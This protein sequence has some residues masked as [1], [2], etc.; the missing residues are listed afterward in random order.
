MSN[1]NSIAYVMVPH[2]SGIATGT[3]QQMAPLAAVNVNGGEQGLLL[4]STMVAS[5]DG[6]NPVSIVG[7]TDSA[8]SVAPLSGGFTNLYQGSV[9]RLTGYDEVNNVW[10]RLRAGI[11]DFGPA[12]L[13]VLADKLIAVSRLQAIGINAEQWRS[14]LA[15]ASDTDGLGGA[16]ND[17][18]LMVTPFPHGFNGATWDRLRTLNAT[19]DSPDS[20]LSGAQIAGSP[21]EWSVNNEPAVAARATVTKANNGAGTR[22][23]CKSITA[24]LA[25]DGT[26]S[27]ANVFV[28]LRDGGGA[29]TILWSAT[30]RGPVNSTN[31]I[32]IS[33]LNIVGSD[34]TDMTLEFSAAPNAN[35]QQVV[36]MT[37]IT[38]AS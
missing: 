11:D 8:D 3:P 21:L 2:G 26:A 6:G 20:A 18:S 14:L 13:G 33:G 27:N 9:A 15:C 16:T 37:G 23:V 38:V 22:L 24:T 1:L 31:V 25:C 28:R 34:G 10:N 35:H 32:A 5:G 4:V 7:L 19:A 30:M 29:G 12:D 36:S 17:N